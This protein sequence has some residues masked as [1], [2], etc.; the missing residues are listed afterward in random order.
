MMQLDDFRVPGKSMKVTGNLEIRT[1][2]IAG[3][4]SGT[5][6]VEKGIRPKVLRVTMSIPFSDSAELWDLIKAAETVT[7]SGERKIYTI[8]HRSA[9]AAGIR[10]V[11]FF[12]HMNWEES[13]TLQ[14][15][16]VSFSLK[17]Y[18]SNPERV[19]TRSSSTVETTE[20]DPTVYAKVAKVAQ[21]YYLGADQVDLEIG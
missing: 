7:D 19:E 4:T 17:E 11:R 20:T 10:Q 16:T 1:E 13:D 21:A 5:D 15:W 8:T 6:T 14:M 18:L 9:N 12:E 3:E 2:D